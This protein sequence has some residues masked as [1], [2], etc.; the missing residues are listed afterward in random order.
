MPWHGNP[1]VRIIPRLDVKTAAKPVGHLSAA[2]GAGER[3]HNLV[4]GIH[5]EGLR[6]VGDPAEH[7][8]R[9]YKQGADELLYVDIVASLYGRNSIS[10]LIERTASQIYVPMTVGGGIRTVGDIHN[11]LR[12]GA[13]KVAI[14]TAAVANPALI[15]ESARIFG[16]QCIVISIQ[17]KR[18][19]DGSWE[20]YTDNGRERTGVNAVEWAKRAVA[21]GAGEILL[22]SVDMEGTRKGFDLDLIAAV[23]PH[24]PVPVI[25]C[26]GAGTV[27]HVAAAVQA[28]AD[29]VAVASLLHYNA[30][31]VSSLKTGLIKHGIQVRV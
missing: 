24:V 23:G 10:D 11:L 3:A 22:T 20:A 31:T 29:A 21:L 26:G 1:A 13:D 18:Q 12:A 5:L 28:G 27:E 6:V 9:Y 7:A 2:A 15:S 8:V 4:K 30:V 16:S 25:V 19:G 17:A 14:N